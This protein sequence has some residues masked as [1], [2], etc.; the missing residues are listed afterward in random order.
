MTVDN[1]DAAPISQEVEQFYTFLGQF[2]HLIDRYGCPKVFL[3]MDSKFRN[4][5]EEYFSE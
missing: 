1:Y 2:E 5:I 4:K 3:A